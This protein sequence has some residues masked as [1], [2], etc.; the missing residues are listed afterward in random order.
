MVQIEQHVWGMTP[1]GEAII[2]YTM[3]NDKGA[4]VKISNFGAAIVSVTM[5][6]REGRMADVVLGYKHPE[7][8]FFDGA[9]SGKSVGRC[10]NRIAFGRMTVEGKE[11]ALEVNNGPNHL[12]GGTKNFANRIW[13][14]RVETN[15][16]V[17]SLLSEDGDQN[18][19]G[20]LNVEAAFD[21]DDENSLE[22]TYLA[23][24]DKTTVVNLTNHVYF[25]LAG[26]GSGSVL[27]HSSQVLEMNDKQIP[28][29]RLLDAAGTPQDFREFRP[30]R[31]GIDSEFNHIRDFKGYDH[32]FVIDGWKPNILGEVG[33]LCVKGPGVMTCYYRDPKATAEVLKD[34]WLYTGDMAK[35]DDEGF[36]YLVDRKKDV[37]ISGGENIYP[38]QIEDF[39]HGHEAVKDVAVI[40]LPDRRL[41]EI[42]AA[43]IE[44]KPGF[45]CSEEE[46]NAYC[47]QLPRYKRPHKIIFAD[48]PRNAT[49]KIE[50]PKLRHI[51]RSE[52]LVAAQTEADQ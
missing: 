19:P 31:P 2:L 51:Y 34:G 13:E 49:G 11:Y 29:G 41:G 39:L 45:S 22:I 43:I 35:Q 23:R 27:D 28:T 9:A 37:I 3:R 10:A 48:V 14:S 7:G 4:E 33:E 47:R 44:C 17:M 15:R 42:S 16:V 24:T 8:Y 30:F 25:N 38:V 26:E 46:I 52:N 40:G 18:Y 1:E 21:F 5:P 6:D 50:K 36:I 20:E 32:P 12:H